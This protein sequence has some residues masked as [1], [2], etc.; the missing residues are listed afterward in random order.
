MVLEGRK[1]KYER[2]AA[3]IPKQAGG[4]QTGTTSRG[5]RVSAGRG[6]GQDSTSGSLW[7]GVCCVL[8]CTRRASQVDRVQPSSWS[9]MELGTW[10]FLLLARF[11]CERASLKSV[12]CNVSLDHLPATV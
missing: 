8:L 10:N 2:E 9:L 12:S 11:T 7:C 1:M 6:T 5:W 4:S 3:D